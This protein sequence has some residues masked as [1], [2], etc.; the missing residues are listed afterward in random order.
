MVT[1][2]QA[3]GGLLLIAVVIAVAACGSANQQEGTPDAAK[4]CDHI[5]SL[6]IASKGCEDVVGK[7]GP[8]RWDEMA[9]CVMA[10]ATVADL[11]G[12][13]LGPGGGD[14][15]AAAA[16]TASVDPMP[17]ASRLDPLRRGEALELCDGMLR[18]EPY[19]PIEQCVEAL[20]GVSPENWSS[21]KKC[22]LESKLR[23]DLVKCGV[24]FSA[25]SSAESIYDK[26]AS[27]DLS[28]AAARCDDEHEEN[29]SL[30]GY[31]KREERKDHRRLRKLIDKH[32][33]EGFFFPMFER[34]MTEFEDSHG[35]RW[36]LT[37]YCL[38]TEIE[39]MRKL[40]RKR[41]KGEIDSGIL[42][43]CKTEW[44][45]RHSLME[46]CVRQQTEAKRF[47]T[48]KYSDSAK[49]PACRNEW[50]ENHRMVQHCIEN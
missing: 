46:H 44:G 4:L 24:S 14:V 16:E 28:G 26:V 19:L 45:D 33:D 10:S 43:F 29:R 49:L 21:F 15:E 37:H 3:L 1:K 23:A 32:R 13:G 34:C 27:D 42:A 17:P 40:A 12:C 2:R 6:G 5:V 9:R 25:G 48:K 11:G 39:D 30:R 31:C 38:K 50:G 18:I 41:E 8:E 22:V 35:F 47:I 20:A 36:G 7:V